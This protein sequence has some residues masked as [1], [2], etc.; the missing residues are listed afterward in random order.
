MANC[1]KVH[2]ARRGPVGWI[3]RAVTEAQVGVAR[4]DPTAELVDAPPIRI[5]SPWSVQQPDCLRQVGRR[6]VPPL[7]VS[8]S[9]STP[10]TKSV[11]VLPTN[12][13]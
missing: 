1:V 6:L 12:V 13:T 2:T 10:S 8:E 7:N 4:I 9:F 3:T 5:L 11:A